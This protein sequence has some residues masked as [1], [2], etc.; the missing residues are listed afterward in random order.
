MSPHPPHRLSFIAVVVHWWILT[1]PHEGPSVDSVIFFSPKHLIL[2][3]EHGN[4]TLIYLICFKHCQLESSPRWLKFPTKH[5]NSNLGLFF[6]RRGL[7]TYPQTGVDGENLFSSKKT[8]STSPKVVCSST[9]FTLWVP[10]ARMNCAHESIAV[11][12]INLVQVIQ[13]KAALISQAPEQTLKTLFTRD[14][15][16]P[17]LSSPTME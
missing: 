15:S 14:N 12:C 17:V 10:V 11:M 7:A 3:R 9:A 2:P 6:V 8:P 16:G 4:R 13:T 1:A 5:H